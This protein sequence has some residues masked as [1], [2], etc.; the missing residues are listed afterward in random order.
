[1]VM[2]VQRKLLLNQDDDAA[3]ENFYLIFQNKY[4]FLQQPTLCLL[5]C[6]FFESIILHTSLLMPVRRHI[7]IML[8]SFTHILSVGQPVC[9][10]V[11]VIHSIRF[12]SNFH[13]R[14]SREIFSSKKAQT[15]QVF[16]CVSLKFSQKF[17]SKILLFLGEDF[18][19][20]IFAFIA[21]YLLLLFSTTKN[22]FSK[23]NLTE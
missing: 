5:V 19:F 10:S 4:L 14:T 2:R 18:Y 21:N 15:S 23:T 7:T 1:M 6:L 11:R 3:K 16:V 13:P 9:Q 20:G 22:L 8:R 17:L 12:T